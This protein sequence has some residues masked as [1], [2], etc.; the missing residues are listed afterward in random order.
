MTVLE[1]LLRSRKY[2]L[3]TFK[4]KDFCMISVNDTSAVLV[5]F[6]FENRCE[7]ERT[8]LLMQEYSIAHAITFLYEQFSSIKRD[9]NS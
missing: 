8:L 9:S 1:A 3:R 2:Q 6:L 7:E 4:K 5:H